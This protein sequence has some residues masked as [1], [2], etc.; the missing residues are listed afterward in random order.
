MLTRE[1]PVTHAPRERDLLKAMKVAFFVYPMAFQAPGGGETQ[2]L[3]TKEYLEHEGVD[4]RFFDPW[5]D[6]LGTYNILHTFGSVKDCLNG[7]MVAHAMGV[8]TVLSTICWYSWKSAWWTYPDFQGRTVSLARQFAKSFFPFLPSMRKRMMDYSN[9][10]FPNSQTEAEQLTRFFCVPKEKIFI[11]PNGV[12]PKFQD[13]TPDLFIDA[14]GLKDFILCIGRIEPRKNQLNMI[15]ALKG[16]RVPLVF[17]GDFVR[18]YR[19]YY[20]ACRWEAG[21][22]VYFLGALPHDSELLASAYAA[23]NTFLLASWLE[24][25][26]L[27]ALEAALAGAKVVITDQGATREYFQD[28]VTYVT[29]DRLDQIRR[30]ALE[31]FEKPKDVRLQEHIRQ[32]YL[33]KH[34]A[35]KTL[36]GYRLLW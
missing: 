4:V 11:V 3:K 36:E 15:R 8:K 17:I 33:W 1:A 31:A 22:N 12:D 29:P 26:G 9:L 6:S 21:D 19:S 5:H 18:E 20:E 23:C 28:H 16:S 24:T 14:Y 35:R 32:N 25:P 7:I 34:V 10:L 13:A 2:L 30:R 27:A